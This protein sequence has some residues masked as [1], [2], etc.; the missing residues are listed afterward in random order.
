MPN[1][2]TQFYLDELMSEQCFCGRHK[3]PRHS[4]CWPCYSSLPRHLQRALYDHI[5]ILEG[6][7]EAYEEAGVPFH[8]KHWGE[9]I[10]FD[11]LPGNP[12]KILRELK[13]SQI[14]SWHDGRCSYR[15]GS[16]RTGRLLDGREWKEFPK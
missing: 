1:R 5:L 13:R 6:Y 9:W 16:Q 2:D 14:H 4:F 11:D 8:F 7:E 10:G 15:L 12:V 3:K